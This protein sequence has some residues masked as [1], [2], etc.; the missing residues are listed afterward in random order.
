MVLWYRKFDLR[1]NFALGVSNCVLIKT[2][3]FDH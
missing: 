3:K 1:F 2:L